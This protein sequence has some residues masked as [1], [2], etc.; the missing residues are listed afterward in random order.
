MEEMRWILLVL[1][2]LLV[3]GIYLFG[4]WSKSDVHTDSQT[5]ERIEPSIINSDENSKLSDISQD[6]F[7]KKSQGLIIDPT[8]KE[9]E[10]EK[11]FVV[12]VRLVAINNSSY[13]G[14]D[15]VLAL[16]E[17][18]M[19]LGEYGIFHYYKDESKS[20]IFSAASLVEPGTFDLKKIKDQKIPG[21][22]F[23]MSLPLAVNGIEAFD[24][25][26]SVVKK[27]S[28]TLKGELL[29]ES[30]SSFSI[31]RERYIREQVIEYLF[32]IKKQNSSN[33]G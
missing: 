27:V 9:L 22:T 11:K 28:I 20:I 21:I 1:G 5:N 23:F 19:Q 17:H 33:H 7:A 30:G 18:G 31:Q 8:F 32:E 29:D 16:R 15:L 26:L 12:T 24:E 10:P 4:I 3:L 6:D 25:M 2:G 14:D 13:A